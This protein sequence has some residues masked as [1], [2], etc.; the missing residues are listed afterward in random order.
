MRILLVQCCNLPQFVFVWRRL[1]ARHPDWEIEGLAVDRP[2]VHHYAD[3]LL[4]GE[5]IHFGGMPK[6]TRN[7]QKVLFPLLNRGYGRIKWNA[8]RLGGTRVWVDYSGSLGELS[9]HDLVRSLWSVR[10]EP[11]SEFEEY[12]EEFPHPPLGNRILFVES[13]PR[14]DLEFSASI[15][16]ELKDEDAEIVRVPEGRLLVNWRRLRGRRFDGAIVFFTGERGFAGLKLLPFLLGIRRIQIFNERG[17][18]F[19]ADLRSLAGF[20]LRRIRNGVDLRG[21]SPR[22]LF[23]QTETRGYSR[24]A[25]EKL[26][27]PDLFPNARILVLCRQEDRPALSAVPGVIRCLTF[28]SG[29]EIAELWRLW[30]SVQ[31]FDP[32][33]NCAVFT[34]R[35]VFRKQ[36]LAYF[37]LAGRHNFALNA[38]LDGYW[39]RPS[40][41]RRIFRREPL[42]TAR[43]GISERVLLIQ[44]ETP[45][46]TRAAAERLRRKELAPGAELS[47]L[48]REKDRSALEDLVPAERL[49][50]Y[51]RGQ[52]PASLWRLRRRLKSMDFRVKAAI[53]TGHPTFRP[54]KLFFFLAPGSGRLIFNARLDAY[55]LT[56]RNLPRL[57]RTE[58]LLFPDPREGTRIVLFQT[59]VAAYVKAAHARLM[60]Q[61]LFPTARILLFCRED[62]R[63][64]LESLE[65]VEVVRTFNSRSS[66]RELVGHWR[67]IRRFKPQ[68]YC[69]LFTGRAAF[70]PAK[71]FAL[72]TGLRRLLILN[73]GLDAYWLRPT[74]LGRLFR[75]EPLLF[76]NQRHPA[77][78]QDVLLLE[79]EGVE[80]MQRAI[81][82]LGEPHVVT[83]AR[84]TVFCHQDRSARYTE[85]PNVVRVV[86]YGKATGAN[87]RTI[88]R[89]IRT[90]PEVIAAVFS[91]RRVFLKQ[92][93]LFWLVRA[94]NR[95]AFNHALDCRYLRRRDLSTFLNQRESGLRPLGRATRQIVKGLLFLPR[96]AY[97]LLWAFFWS[98][99]RARLGNSNY[100][101]GTP[102][103]RE[104]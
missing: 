35:P 87:I 71:L 103:S 2:H 3:R 96:F 81:Q 101:P 16:R 47:L 43:L 104:A 30:R 56:L 37:A 26:G 91:G 69:A 40:T 39:L 93:L 61:G 85:L 8:W 73:A 74:N 67:Q 60:Q 38:G 25:L 20:C 22:V 58:P 15:L 7:F 41:F 94:R 83:G 72:A 36:K 28:S 100:T 89:L 52:S 11:D 84:I 95:L 79:T 76:G 6:G 68:V 17:T 64:F 18:H 54:G 31:R 27:E 98:R 5:M 70:R 9:G 42:L 33:M 77:E 45:L 88:L 51:R 14:K 10:D 44:T 50:T 55:W 12:L 99:A 66:L 57:F 53:F 92:K 90:R 102:G 34:G 19:S 62:D 32:Q 48:C 82:V 24:A 46:Y 86:T 75:R 78:T 97:L 13:A 21:R 80:E 4:S 59:E 23:I 29:L 1:A 63:T 49:Y 65:G